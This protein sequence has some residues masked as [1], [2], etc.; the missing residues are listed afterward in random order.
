MIE[1]HC[2]MKMKALL[3]VL[4]ISTFAHP[5][6]AQDSLQATLEQ[7][8][9]DRTLTLRH[10]YQRSDQVYGEKIDPRKN[11]VE[12]PWALCGR[13]RVSKIRLRGNRLQLEGKRIEYQ[14]DGKQSMPGHEVRHSVKID[15]DLN[16]PLAS[17]EQARAALERVFAL[18]QTDVAEVTRD[19]WRSVESLNLGETVYSGK[20]AKPPRPLHTPDPE[21]P[22]DR[23]LY[24]ADT[25]V[26]LTIVIDRE[27][28]VA[29]AIFLHSAGNSADNSA[30]ETVKKWTF[31]PATLNGQ[32]VAV[33]MT[34]EV[35]FKSY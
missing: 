6:L 8:Y 7:Q 31:E 34:V 21:F 3:F 10:P 5:A 33:E 26:S 15:I 25:T 23:I 4:F 19:L 20:D 13:I 9:I 12:G 1:V 27:G 30:A 32:P 16:R 2:M 14:G 18:N 11:G 28:R 17:A 29:Q 35:S 24:R 22:H